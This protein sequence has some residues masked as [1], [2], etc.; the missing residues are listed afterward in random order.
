M[1]T[2][3][4]MFDGPDGVGKTTQLGLAYD[5][6]ASKGLK[7]LKTRINGGSPIGEEIRKAYLS[8]HDRPVE[9]DMYLALAI[10]YALGAYLKEQHD[11]DVILVDRSPYSIIAYQSFASGLELQKAKEA[12]A[13]SAQVVKPDMVVIYDAG[14]E[15]LDKRLT[16]RT[17]KTTD[18][19]EQ[20]AADYHAR[21]REG[22]MFAAKEYDLPTVDASGSIDEVHERTMNTIE[23]VIV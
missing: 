19:F 20:Q 13:L 12:C 2:K 14:P 16:E 11:Y 3:I 6:L 9:T 18:Y 23:S 1:P 21:L 15:V 22:Y 17:D 4:I 8:M 5:A 10:G 7:V